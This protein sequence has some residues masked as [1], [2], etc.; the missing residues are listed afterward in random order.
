[1]DQNSRQKIVT[2]NWKMHKTVKEAKSFVQQLIPLIENSTTLV[3]LAV[4]FTVLY[5]LSQEFMESNVVFGAQNMNDATEGAF[6][7]EIAGKM[8]KG[9]GA[10]F[11]LL[12]HSERRHLFNE[13]NDY[14]NRKI[15][16]AV[17]DNL[18]PVLCIGE[19]Q[20]E[21]E[22]DQT[23]EVL[24]KQLTEC[25]K[26]LDAHQLKN[27]IVA[28]E[29]VWAIGTG[30]TAT[31]EIAENTHQYC[32]EQ[33]EQLFSA[34]FAEKT[35]IQYGGS[36]NPSN[37]KLLLSQPDIDGLLVG[38]ASLSLETFGQIVNDSQLNQLAKG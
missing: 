19:T 1:M 20:A 6:T 26:D 36:V 18:Q 21:Y 3:Y 34:E 7:G 4:P 15:K 12:G 13:S 37:A 28:Y 29:P 5:P 9:A 8:L 25:L 22:A 32:R 33:L 23:H 27:L 11:V 31:P 17:L 10:K 30:E 14:V 35:I 24:R 2:G 38:G 16:R